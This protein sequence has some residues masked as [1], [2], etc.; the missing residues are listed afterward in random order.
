MTLPRP[1]FAAHRARLLERLAPDEAVLVLGAP[2]VTRNGDAEYRYRP[3]S[4]LWWLTGFGE[5]GS[6]VFVKPGEAPFT[7]FVRPRDKARETWTGRRAG[8]EGAIARFGADD[9]APIAELDEH[10]GRLLQGVRTLHYG[11]GRDADMDRRLQAVIARAARA[12]RRNG[13]E[14]PEVFVS[15]GRTLHELRLYKTDDEVACLRAAAEITDEAFR[16]CMA[17]VAPGKGEWALDALLQ[18]TFRAHGS[19]GPGYTP[20]VASG[21]NAT[22]LHYIDNN[23]VCEAGELVLIDAG[24]EVGHYTSDVTR[25]FPV[26]GRFEGAGRDVYDAVLSAQLAAIEATAPGATFMDVHDATIR[27]LTGAMVDLG[28][29]QGDVDELIE[30]EAYKRYYMHGTSHWLGIDVHD[31]GA[32]AREGSSRVLDPGMV[33]TIEPGLYIAPDDEQAPEALRGIGVRIEDDVLVTADGR[34]VLTAAIPKSIADVE[35]A[36]KGS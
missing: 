10:L 30:T 12:G 15:P 25:T 35:A 3:D 13:L 8:P 5:P 29:L 21:D 31:V 7:L 28:L 22:I 11:F 36:C 16:A 19:E 24:C 34:D 14:A 33:L 1:D 17:A 26:D 27:H 20:I 23:D 6:A 4:D 9:A 18:G 2:E 32:Y